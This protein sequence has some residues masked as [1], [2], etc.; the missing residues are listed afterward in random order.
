MESMVQGQLKSYAGVSKS[1]NEQNLTPVKSPP[2][3]HPTEKED[4]PPPTPIAP[5]KRI[6]YALVGLGKLT[7]EQILPAFGSCKYSKVVALV[8]GDPEKA[9]NVARQY[10]VSPSAIYTYQ[11]FDSIKNNPDIDVVYIVLPNSMHAEYTIRS[12]KAGKH[13]LCEKP[14]ATSSKDAQKMIDAC[15]DAGKKLMIAYRIQYEPHNRMI[16]SW[17][18]E[19]K[20]GKARLIEA[21]NVQNSGD[22][23]QWRLKK[24]LAGGGSLPDIGLYCLNTSRFLLG[25][26]P[27]WVSATVFSTPGDLRFTD[28]EE[29]VLFQV[30]FPGGTLINCSCSYGVHDSKRYRVFADKGGWYGMDP[31]FPYKGLKME[32]SHAEGKVEWKENPSLGEKDQFSLEIDHMSRCVL[33]NKTPYTPGEEGL[34]DQVIMEAIYES[35]RLGKPVTLKKIDG[36]DVFRGS[37]PSDE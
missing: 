5:A 26:E 3:H 20:Y 9:A 18:R 7:L 1:L 2:M 29:S 10:G 12:A 24:E 17:V 25:E 28:V 11:N 15:K 6:G 22:G 34:Q 19:N 31:A 23:N 35:A 14:M 4:G 8:S 30:R 27:E 36:I 33:E 37:A 13:V 16:Q 21:T 32:V